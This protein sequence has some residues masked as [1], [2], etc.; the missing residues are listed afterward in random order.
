LV[1]VPMLLP[2]LLLALALLLLPELPLVPPDASSILAGVTGGREAG[3][4]HGGTVC[5]SGVLPLLAPW[6]GDL[7]FTT[8]N[9]TVYYYERKLAWDLAEIRWGCG[10]RKDDGNESFAARRREE[11]I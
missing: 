7:V 10:K 6:L 3:G 11:G 1:G 5:G 9:A 8:D 2:L 4:L